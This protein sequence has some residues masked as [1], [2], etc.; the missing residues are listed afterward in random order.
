MTKVYSIVYS[1]VLTVNDMEK[2]IKPLLKQIL[3]RNLNKIIKNILF[4]NQIY[5]L[6]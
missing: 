2:V 4:Y 3:N 5:S 6:I 1:K